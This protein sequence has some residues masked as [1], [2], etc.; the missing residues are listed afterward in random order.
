MK[1][2]VKSFIAVLGTKGVILVLGFLKVVVLARELGTDGQGQYALAVTIYT[3]IF[4]VLCMGLYSAQNYYLAKDRNKLPVIW[5]NSIGVSTLSGILCFA[6]FI[7]IRLSGR[8][9]YGIAHLVSICLLIVP[10]YLYYYLQQQ[11]L[12]IIDRVRLMNFLDIITAVVP[13]MVY[14]FLASKNALSVDVALITVIL[15]NLLVDV[16]GC[17]AFIKMKTK[18]TISFSFYMKCLKL[19]VKAFIAVFLSFLGLKVGMYMASYWLSDTEVG[20]YSVAVNLADVVELFYATLVLVLTPKVACVEDYSRRYAV[21]VKIIIG[22]C[23]A[24][25]FIALT[26]ELVCGWFIPVLFGQQYYESIRVFRI[27]L[28]GITFWGVAEVFQLW[29]W[30]RKDYREAIISYGA[31]TVMNLTLIYFLIR[32]WGIIGIAIASLL[33]YII[34]FCIL[35]YFFCKDK[36]SN[37]Y[38]LS[39]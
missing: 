34:V 21:M 31:G 24:S 19:G 12:L 30:A 3:T 13:L 35:G 6:V 7:M 10:F 23:I 26:G 18:I 33:S 8:G 38:S 1:N 37:G 29:F 5:G 20:K 15:T 36:I 11:I 39:K 25:V 28:I 32:Q 27:L 9:E 16:I 17:I 14:V 4:Q 22:V 2:V